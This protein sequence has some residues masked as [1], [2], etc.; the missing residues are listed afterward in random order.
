MKTSEMGTVS[1]AAHQLRQDK[2]QD[3]RQKSQAYFIRDSD[4]S[5]HT[6]VAH[7]CVFITSLVDDLRKI[8]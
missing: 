2:H 1:A 4:S 7:V 6:E 3:M 8:F 5:P